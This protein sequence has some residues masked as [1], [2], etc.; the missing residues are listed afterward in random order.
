MKNGCRIFLKDYLALLENNK[1][2]SKNTISAALPVIEN[3]DKLSL[4]V[5]RNNRHL[6][7]K[8]LLSN[9]VND[10][11]HILISQHFE[12]QILIC[13]YSEHSRFQLIFTQPEAESRQS[14]ADQHSYFKDLRNFLIKRARITPVVGPDGAGKTAMLD[15]LMNQ[16]PSPVKRYRFKNLIRHNFFYQICRPRLLK[17]VESEIPK[18]IKK[19]AVKDYYDDIIGDKIIQFGAAYYPF[20]AIRQYLS[21]SHLFVDRYFHDFIIQNAR[22]N[23]RQ[24]K[25]RDNWKN[26]L[27]RSP[28]TYWFL[29]LDATNGV[30]LSRK[31]E[32]SQQA[33]TAYRECM[34]EMYL[35]K[36]SPAFSYINTELPISHC[37]ETIRNMA[38]QIG[39]KL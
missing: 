17:S 39:Y 36:P 29:Q 37:V 19:A 1:L 20:L 15:E 30:I 21:R 6:L 14:A 10:R 38:Q 34:F 35:Q 7:I 32:L 3:G 24:S 13:I 16:S 11:I 2:L 18:N 28:D 27:K 23:D 9:L 25:L 31:L 26:L 8:L 33:I 5:S 12:S 22:F 4:P